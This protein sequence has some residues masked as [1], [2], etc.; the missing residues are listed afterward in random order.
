LGKLKVLN[1]KGMKVVK[2]KEY[3]GLLEFSRF[4]GV[5]YFGHIVLPTYLKNA[6]YVS[7][8]S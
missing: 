7:K 5:Q 6:K 2:V 4:G 3:E 8:R 1:E